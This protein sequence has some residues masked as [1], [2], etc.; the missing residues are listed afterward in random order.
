MDGRNVA[1]MDRR[2]SGGDGQRE[3]AVEVTGSGR[4]Q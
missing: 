2:G 4:R 1:T 3:G